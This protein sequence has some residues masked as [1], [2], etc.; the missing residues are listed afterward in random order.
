MLNG[1][2]SR[3]PENMAQD[4][5][6][7]RRE[8]LR[9]ITDWEKKISSPDLNEF[10]MDSFV[11]ER[12]L[13]QKGDPSYLKFADFSET[14]T[15]QPAVTPK[16][17]SM[18]TVGDLKRRLMKEN[19]KLKER[20]MSTS[21]LFSNKGQ[22]NVEVGAQN[23]ETGTLEKLNIQEW[24]K[25]QQKQDMPNDLT[26]SLEKKA[27]IKDI[28]SDAVDPSGMIYMASVAA[29]AATSAGLASVQQK[30]SFKDE[31]SLESSF[32][33]SVLKSKPKAMRSRRKEITRED[34]RNAWIS[35]A[36]SSNKTG[37]AGVTSDDEQL[38]SSATKVNGVQFPLKPQAIKLGEKSKM[39]NML[40]QIQYENNQMAHMLS[41]YQQM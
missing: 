24:I 3:T 20:F 37:L 18:A 6:L 11:F 7:E 5:N 29:A 12:P 25:N 33:P 22:K 9:V 21:S 14:K 28:F 8:S 23:L 13:L 27:T 39:K 16:I 19:G 40:S 41:S 2:C 32:N 15:I 34:L 38:S 17:F 31:Q 10:H 30:V 26:L 36:R 4:L 1:L 35:D